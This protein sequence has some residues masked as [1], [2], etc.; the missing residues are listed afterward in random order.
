MPDLEGRSKP[1]KRDFTRKDIVLGLA[2][3]TTPFAGVTPDQSQVSMG[4][5]TTE[6]PIYHGERTAL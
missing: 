3:A 5:L 6:V 2:A 1:E 4:P